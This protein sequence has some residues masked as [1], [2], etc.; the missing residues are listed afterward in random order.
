M[1]H[2]LKMDP[3]QVVERV[4]RDGRVCAQSLCADV[5]FSPKMRDAPILS[6][7]TWCWAKPS[8][9]ARPRSTSPTRWATP[10]PMSICSVDRRHHQEHARHAR[11]HH[12]LG[13][14]PR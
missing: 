8:R 2:K 3:E 9:P 11:R 13:A 7:C 5:E 4:S 14:L 12:G 6:S 10:R 1:K